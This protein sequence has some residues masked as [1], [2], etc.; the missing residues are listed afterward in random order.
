MTPASREL[1]DVLKVATSSNDQL[2]QAIK[3]V[4]ANQVQLAMEK[5][6]QGTASSRTWKSKD[7]LIMLIEPC[8]VYPALGKRAAALI[9][10]APAKMLGPGFIPLLG[11]EQWANETLTAWL[12]DPSVGKPTKNAI[13]AALKNAPRPAQRNGI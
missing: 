4:D 5:A 11:A 13:T 7:E 8:R 6:W 2:T 10:L 1:R 12:D 9:R 3:L